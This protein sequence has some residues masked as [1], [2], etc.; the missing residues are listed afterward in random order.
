MRLT[1]I[2]PTAK[3]IRLLIVSIRCSLTQ[4]RQEPARTKVMRIAGPQYITP[5]GAAGGRYLRLIGELA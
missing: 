2:G 4:R 5:Q 3:D 1:S